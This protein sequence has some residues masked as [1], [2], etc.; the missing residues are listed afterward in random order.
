MRRGLQLQFDR[1][2]WLLRQCST[3]KHIQQAHGFMVPR[4]LVH[5]NL[6]LARFIDTCSS[7]GLSDY[8]SSVF[9]HCP[10][11]HQPTIYLYNT[12]IKAHAL[13]PSPSR[14]V[15]LFNSIQLAALRPDSYSFSFVLKAVVR[16]LQL[17]L[18][19]QIHCH[20]IATGFAADANVL[21]ALVHM[22]SSCG[23]VSHARAL[24]DGAFFVRDAALW[25][26]MIGGYAKLGDL[27]SARHVFELMPHSI[28]NVIS[29]TALIAGYAQ[30]N[31]PHEAITVFQRMQVENVE[32]DEI[33]VLAALSACA[34]LGALHLGEWIHNYIDRHGFRKLVSLNNALIDMYAKSGNIMKAL[35]VFENTKCK[36]VVTWT[37]M[38]A[39]LALHGLAREALQMFSQMERAQIKPNHITFIAILSACS[40][41][42]LV[43]LGHW[44][45]NIMISKYGIEPKIVHYG[46]MIDLLGRA[47]YLEEAHEL[48]KQMPFE[49][50]PAIWGSLLAASNIHGHAELGQHALQ[51]LIMLEPHNS[52]NYALLSNIY[53]ALGRW[54]DSGM[55]RK[56]MR[57]TGVKKVPGGSSVEVNNRVHEFMAGDKSHSECTRIYGVLFKIF[58]QLKPAGHLQN[59]CEELLEFDE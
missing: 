4:S 51:H 44:Y 43:E 28:R 24:F 18:G 14:A 33:A 41:G 27:D 16:L 12:M 37:T 6:I 19:A 35:R 21:T 55:L 7:L 36:T 34:H 17:Q 22:Y 25:N 45:F 32:P 23:C 26:A 31:R 30:T 5:E 56:I 3:R 53:G 54:N 1:V 8:A 49:A 50:N 20:A 29:W 57:D 38:I 9:A 48:V 47:G 2:S 59:D 13:S 40:H 58:R 11:T 46:C 52:G 42:R 10:A 39:G 15:S